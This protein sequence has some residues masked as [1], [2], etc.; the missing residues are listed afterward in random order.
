MLTARQ[1]PSRDALNLER[2]FE[3]RS[4]ERLALQSDPGFEKAADHPAVPAV[5]TRIDERN[6]AGPARLLKLEREL[7]DFAAKQ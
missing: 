6:R 5:L 2:A 7:G 1:A 3:Q 4:R